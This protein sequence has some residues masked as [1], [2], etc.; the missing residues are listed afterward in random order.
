MNVVREGYTEGIGFIMDI[1]QRYSYYGYMSYVR[2]IVV[3][4]MSRSGFQQYLVLVAHSA[5]FATSWSFFSHL[6]TDSQ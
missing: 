3:R 1:F 2:F 5:R 4:M 6:R